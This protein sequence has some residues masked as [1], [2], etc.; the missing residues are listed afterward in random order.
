MTL[1]THPDVP[2]T[3]APAL[4]GFHHLGLTVRAIDDS[5]AWYAEVLGMVRASSSPIPP[6][7]AIPW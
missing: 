3:T 4:T 2:A 6:A 5:E 7:G 1:T